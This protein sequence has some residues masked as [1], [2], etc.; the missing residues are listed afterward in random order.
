MIRADTL[1]LIAE[2]P[3]AHGIFDQP[4]E[5]RRTVYCRERSVGQTEVYQ[6]KAAGLN[7]ELKLILSHYFEYQHEKLCEYKG[8]R[9]RILRTYIN[10][11]DEIELTLQRVTGNAVEVGPGV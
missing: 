8:T 7:P 10:E 9:Y 5:V 3:G 4:D 11:G 1:I 6:A 2:I